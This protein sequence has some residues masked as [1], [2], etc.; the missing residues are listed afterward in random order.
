MQLDICDENCELEICFCFLQTEKPLRKVC[1]GNP[2]N[3]SN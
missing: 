1:P 2:G 3:V